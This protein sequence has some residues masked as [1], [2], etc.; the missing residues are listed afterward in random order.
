[1]FLLQIDNQ[2]GIVTR[3]H[4]QLGPNNRLD[5]PVSG[6][7]CFWVSNE[8][9]VW[10]GSTEGILL[11]KRYTFG[12]YSGIK[13]YRTNTFTFASENEVLAA[14]GS[15][16]KYTLKEGE[17]SSKEITKGYR[18]HVAG[19]GVGK[20]GWWIGNSDGDLFY[21]LPN[22]KS[23]EYSFRKRG[24][25]LFNIYIAKDYAA[26]V[27]QSL[28]DDPI[29][30]VIRIYESGDTKLYGKGEGLYSRVIVTREGQDGKLYAGGVGEAHYLYEYDPENDRF[31]DLSPDLPFTPKLEF[32]IH[33][34]VSK[35]DG[36]L[37]L[38][39]TD[40]L[41]KYENGEIERVD[42]EIF[43]ED[44]EIKS[45]ELTPDGGLWMGTSRH[46]LI[47]YQDG[48]VHVFD[49]RHGLP[50]DNL[51][52][53]EL[54]ADLKGRLWVGTGEGL[55][56]SFL[57]FPTPST[58]SKPNLRSIVNENGENLSSNSGWNNLPKLSY[59]DKTTFSFAGAS[60]PINNLEYR[61]KIPTYRDQWSLPQ[62]SPDITLSKL[63]YGRHTLQ[64]QA[65]L[66][67]GSSWSPTKETTF[68][69]ERVWYLQTWAKAL[70][71]LLLIWVIAVG[72]R[73]YNRKL[74]RQKAELEGVIRHRT[75]EL[76]R[77]K[78][79]AE[80]A[81]M[82]KSEFLANM[83]HEIRTPMNGVL[84]MSDLL[85][86]TKLSE[87]QLDYVKTI[88]T[89]CK[90]LLVIINDILDFTKIESGNM[91]LEQEAFQ[92]RSCV[93]DVM[94]M[95]GPQAAA[96]GLDLFY[97]LDSE[98][99][100]Q[101][102]GDITRLRQVLINMVGNA[103]KFTQSGSVHISA[104]KL[105]EFE[106]DQIRIGF[107]V[108]DTGIGIPEE[109]IPKL[110]SAFTQVDASTTRKFGGTGLGLAICQK[111]VNLMGGSIEV[112]SSVGVG[113]T[114]SFDILGRIGE[115]EK[116]D[117][118]LSIKAFGKGKKVWIVEDNELQASSLSSWL[119]S[120]DF[121]PEIFLNAQEAVEKIHHETPDLILTDLHMPGVDGIAFSEMLQ[122]AHDHLPPVF[123]M[124]PLG[125]DLAPIQE[126]GLFKEIMLKPI[127]YA[128]LADLLENTLK[129]NL[130]K[131]KE[132]TSQNEE[133]EIFD[134]RI[135]VV[136][137]NMVNQKLIKRVLEKLGYQIE[138]ADNGS[139]G[140]EKV[141]EGNFNLIF[142]DVQMPVM[143]GLDATRMI[144]KI[145]LG[146]GQPTIIA[147]T[148]NA[149]EGDKE[150]CLKAGMDDYVS[151]P[152]T[153][154][155]IRAVLHK[156]AQQIGKPV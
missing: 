46:G 101:I 34:I 114:F 54:K 39:S 55:S 38:A 113:T 95:M 109:K 15:L 103:I 63:P 134:L 148:A 10:M 99:P 24:G 88:S 21:I 106:E 69:V 9:T 115:A 47:R 20:E 129:G 143:N 25:A 61:Y 84:G 65:R 83:S 152:F 73:L 133:E 92:L 50:N 141:K 14:Y 29:N 121:I 12:R 146:S 41:L 1:V 45:L 2:K 156:Y 7:T 151:K 51:L 107:Q 80:T 91:E 153:I 4:N 94:D 125:T 127:K 90:N 35:G 6:G 68:R 23:K 119:E 145:S 100:H 137:D 49:Q 19:I 118:T 53:R 71:V 150:M 11:L 122:T 89:S 96:K 52:Y 74:Y 120:W 56:L 44:T 16:Y 124:C 135:L 13:G 40:G 104:A 77:A 108:K 93:E 147:M 78:L 154:K 22:G 66:S 130:P 105:H 76:Q 126:R 43:A 136:E 97:R 138:L 98:L 27:C 75:E 8:S 48:T 3:V 81:N 132:H 36:V 57:P 149:I 70:Q 116:V 32:E 28:T 59:S 86:T 112:N 85:L 5:F 18:G 67:S 17:I 123:L 30:G 131:G 142:M 31:L 62:V 110:F 37:W 60:F 111:L 139:I 72:I 155:D 87:E 58:T 42:L 64:V 79:K 102:R 82:A 33:D 128:A 26:W 144:R 140:V 117:E